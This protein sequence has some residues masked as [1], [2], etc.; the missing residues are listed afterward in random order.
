MEGSDLA[1]NRVKLL[2]IIVEAIEEKKGYDVKVLD[3]K[4][5]TIAA[6]QFVFCSSDSTSQ[7]RAIADNILEKLDEFDL[8]VS[9]KEGYQSGEWIALNAAGFIIHIFLPEIREYYGIEKFWED[10]AQDIREREMEARLSEG[11]CVKERKSVSRVSDVKEKA[12]EQVASKKP[13]VKIE[14]ASASKAKKRP[15]TFEQLHEKAGE[16]KR[17]IKEI[18]EEQIMKKKATAPKQS[19]VKPVAEVV[20]ADPGTKKSQKEAI[21]EKLLAIK[22]KKLEALKNKKTP[23]KSKKAVK[24]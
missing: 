6:D 17:S 5:F 10:E 14:K 22:A 16:T 13:S 3:V 1:S 15:E 19:A 11:P 12:I 2:K 23:D 20:P 4:E 7:C 18:I 9:Y 24:K 21:E 8:H